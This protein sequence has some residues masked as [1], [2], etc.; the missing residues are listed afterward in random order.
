MMPTPNDAA[1]LLQSARTAHDLKT[2]R[3]H[4]LADDA[5]VLYQRF[6]EAGICEDHAL[7]LATL[8]LDIHTEQ[9][10]NYE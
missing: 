3:L 5:V 4:A 7:E 6:L 8:T 9:E 10:N 2:A 1:A